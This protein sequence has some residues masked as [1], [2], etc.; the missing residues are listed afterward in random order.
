MSVTVSA[1]PAPAEP[2]GPPPSPAEAPGESLASRALATTLR[3][4]VA[5]GG[6]L[7]VFGAFVMANGANPLQVYS[8][9]W[10]STL[11]RGTSLQQILILATPIVLTALAVVVPARGGMVNVGGE[12]Q[13]I[14]GAVAAAGVGLM[15]D[16]RVNGTVVLILMLVAGTVAGA[17]WAGV[18][19]AMRLTVRVNEAVTTLLLNYVALFV[20]QYLIIGPWRDPGQNGRIASRELETGALLPVLGSS[21]VHIGIA[22]AVIATVAVWVLLRFTTW[23]FRLSVVGGN[24]EAARRAGFNVRKLL[25]GALLLGGAF[26]GLAGVIHLTGKEY[27]LVSTFG[28]NIGYLGFLASW[29]A[30]HRPIPVLVA[31]FALAAI[32]IAGDSLQLR[33]GLPAPTVNIL[34]GLVLI[35]VLGWTTKKGAKP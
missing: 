34:L 17:L 31:S 32:A 35:A 29:L 3:W 33:S 21:K 12:G 18:A 6:A 15:L 23:G 20:M 27:Q 14:I 30:R 16:Q 9:I 22:I 11:A 28:A 13:L 8:D 7:V 5:L 24:A 19:A 2:A 4:V 1:E 10:S 25:L 26:A